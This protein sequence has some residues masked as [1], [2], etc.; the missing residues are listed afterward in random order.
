MKKCMSLPLGQVNADICIVPQWLLGRLEAVGEPLTVLADSKLT[1]NILSDE[2]IIYYLNGVESILQER[3]LHRLWT[4]GLEVWYV[5]AGS[6]VAPCAVM[7]LLATTAKVHKHE[8]QNIYRVDNP[9]RFG[10]IV[11]GHYLRGPDSSIDLTGDWHVCYDVKPVGQS[12]Y[13]TYEVK[14]GPRLPHA[15][16][17]FCKSLLTALSPYAD[18]NALRASKLYA[19]VL[20]NC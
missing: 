14:A 10:H 11:M 9:Q 19:G 15:D 7:D 13:I 5:Q 18:R 4:E 1:G 17:D 2:E 16:R 6:P 8:L 20:D 3:T 12:I